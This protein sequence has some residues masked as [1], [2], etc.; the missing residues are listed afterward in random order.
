MEKVCKGCGI[1]KSESDFYKD[2]GRI[3]SKCKTCVRQRVKIPLEVSGKYKECKSCSIRKPIEDFTKRGS[4]KDGY[5]VRCKM[6]W[7][8]K[9]YRPKVKEGHLFC[10][11][12]KESKRFCLFDKNKASKTGFQ[13]Y[14]KNCRKIKVDKTALNK[15]RKDRKEKEPLFK[16]TSSIRRTISLAFGRVRD[17]KFKKSKRCEDILGCTFEEFKTHIESQFKNWMTWDNYGNCP[18]NDFNCSWHLDHIIPI[19]SAKTEED[20]YLLNHWRNFQPLCSKAN[21][22]KSDRITKI[23]N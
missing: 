3:L 17:K 14:C 20:V 10:N 6:C 23:N 22:E 12:C 7:E 21:I 13:T 8:N 9:I 18:T 11:G 2:R 15:Y 5:E 16:L 1:V 19:S 4:S